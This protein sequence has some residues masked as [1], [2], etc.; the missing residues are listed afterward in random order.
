MGT[1]PISAPQSDSHRY[2]A[3][4]RISEAI[5]AC[6]EPEELATTLASEIGK[7]LQFDH[8]Y[9]VVLKENSKEIEYLVWGKGPLPFPDLPLEDLPW[10]EAVRSRDPQHTA[11]WDTEERYPRFKEWAR[12]MDLGSGLRVPLTTPHRQ[13]GVFGINRDTVNPFTEEEISF[14]GLIGRVVA[15]ALDDGLNLRRAQ[16][17]NDQL[18]LLLDLTNRITSNLEFR[19]LL[20][21]IAANIR[22]VIRA[23]AVD[24][25]LPDGVSDKFRVFAMDF[26]HGKGVVKEEL[27]VTPS[28][29]V[30]KALD[31]LKP[32]VVDMRERN[33]LTSE[34][35]DILAAEGIKT[36]CNIPLANRG[37]ALGILSILRTTETPFSPGDVDFLSRA[38]GQI[39]IA[40]E[41]ALAYQEISQLKDKLA[42]EKLYLE[43]EIRSEMNFEN[44]IGNSAALK[45]VLELVETVATSDS[46]VLLLGE[47]GTGKELIARAIHDRSRRKERTFVKLNCAAIPTGLLESELFGHEKGAFTGA[48]IQK[49]GRMELADQGTLFLDEVG[50]IPIEIQP[51]LL[52]A[53]QER[54]FERLGS[55]H[56]RRVNIRLV[57]ATNRDLEEMIAARE[58]RSDLYYRLHVFPIRIPPLRER[59]EDIPQLVSYFVQKFAKQMQKK[60][61]AISPAVMKGLMAWEWPGNIRELENFIERAVI[62]TR[63]RS[64][65]APLGELRKKNTVAFPHAE[66][67]N[68]E[69]V[70][71]E[72]TDS[73]GD[74]TSVADEYERRQRDEIIRALTACK[75]RVGGADGAA[76]SLGMN[77]TTFL[78]R[79]K[80]FGI[81][82]KQYA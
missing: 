66:Q 39:A 16:H 43:E 54:E 17:Q 69:Q 37:R 47:T 28:A 68:V 33:E 42:Q 40:I 25:A 49:V 58:F 62:V 34:A 24:V 9:F 11:D 75:G 63:G 59:K 50:D 80:K 74:Q 73:Q 15:F 19:D 2:E 8:L 60:I 29:A 72:R 78:S 76:A 70:A 20:R 6:R 82:A 77:R 13:L 61:E 45:H 31:T 44:I 26:P 7:F 32:V 55:I 52:R 65:E 36:F 71:G 14:L 35:S 67:H 12:K 22:E 57:A 5:A 10:W 30:K 64:L 1:D 3:V 46:T 53:L 81:Y 51:K 4:L 23:D 27:L 56:T 41:N 21:A 48:I 79:M 18:Q 38:S